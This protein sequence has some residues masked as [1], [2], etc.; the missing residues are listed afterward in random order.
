VLEINQISIN[1]L[2][3][4]EFY[5]LGPE[6]VSGGKNFIELE[7]SITG[8]EKADQLSLICDGHA[9]NYND[10]KDN[11]LIECVQFIVAKM[12]GGCGS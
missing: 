6:S 12:Q 2:G 11:V 4:T 9:F 5:P 7:V 8:A 3:G 10:L 1:Q